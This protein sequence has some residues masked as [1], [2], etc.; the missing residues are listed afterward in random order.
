MAGSPPFPTESL[1]TLENWKRPPFNRWA[2]HHVRELIPTARISCGD[3]PPWELPR[4]E[5][6]LD[7]I[8]FTTRAGQFPLGSCLPGPTPDGFLVIHRDRIVAER[9]FNDLRPD[10]HPL[11]M[12][13]SKS[14]T[15]LVA[16]ALAGQGALDVTARVKAIVP[17]LADAAFESAT[18]QHLLDMRTG[19]RFEENDDDP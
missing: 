11:L 10:T 9:Y 12:S 14:V 3:G 7:G 16:G 18:V 15:G 2:F 6:D 17:E 13:V 19:I 8:R 5:R 1:V 4:A